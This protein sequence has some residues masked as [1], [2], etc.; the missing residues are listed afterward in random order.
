MPATG[1]CVDHFGDSSEFQQLVSDYAAIGSPAEWARRCGEAHG[2]DETYW[3][4]VGNLVTLGT[5]KFDTTWPE[6]RAFRRVCPEATAGAFWIFRFTQL[7]SNDR[8][9]IALLTCLPGGPDSSRRSDWEHFSEIS[10]AFVSDTLAKDVA[11]WIKG[12]GKG[13]S[14]NPGKASAVSASSAVRQAGG[15]R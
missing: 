13:K 9:Y 15:H 6:L 10:V 4:A 1:E 12:S 3:E 7:W 5:R 11:H 8:L 2:H 14:A